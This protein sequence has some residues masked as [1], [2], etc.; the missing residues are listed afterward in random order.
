[1][2]FWDEECKCDPVVIKGQEQIFGCHEC[3]GLGYGKSLI[4]FIFLIVIF[5]GVPLYVS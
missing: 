2:N 1:M 5:I 3:P 4:C